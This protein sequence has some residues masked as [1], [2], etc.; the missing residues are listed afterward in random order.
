MLA[1]I[2]SALLLSN[3][4]T[5]IGGVNCHVFVVSDALLQQNYST[6]NSI[7]NTIRVGS[8]NKTLEEI[9]KSNLSLNHSEIYFLYNI[10]QLSFSLIFQSTVNLTLAG[11]S[12]DKTV[13]LCSRQT[14]EKGAGIVFR[15]NTNVSI[16]NI[17]IQNCGVLHNNTNFDSKTNAP[18][19][20]RLAIL[21]EN[22][23]HLN[24]VAVSTINS[25]GIGV[26]MHSIIGNITLRS[27]RFQNNSVYEN[28]ELSI[29]G[30]GGLFIEMTQDR[31]TK[32]LI[33][34]CD[35]IQNQASTSRVYTRHHEIR[36]FGQG[37]G[38]LLFF[39]GTS[40]NH[41]VCISNCSFVD[42]SAVWGGGIHLFVTGSSQKNTVEISDSMIS[43]NI[44]TEGGGG[45]VLYMVSALSNCDPMKLSNFTV[46]RCT[47][48]KNSAKNVGGGTVIYSTLL[49]NSFIA[50]SNCSHILHFKLCMWSL[51]CASYSAAMDITTRQRNSDPFALTTVS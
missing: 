13:I 2:V 11:C 49:R 6:C 31:D 27:C 22:V 20:F 17:T 48:T 43:K 36:T 18:M 42:N 32:F 35:F 5:Y 4:S 12:Q 23:K 39:K 38:L 24:M 26:G 7:P 33:E 3:I 8:I 19:L 16:M 40:S 14:N 25:N 37:G 45:M 10:Y 9:A 51:N 21:F 41:R 1:F 30:G 29:D 34:N 50:A 44:A 15:N 47:F 46:T 28:E